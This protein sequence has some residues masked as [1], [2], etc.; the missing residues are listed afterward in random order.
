MKTKKNLNRHQLIHSTEEP[1]K[2]YKC[3]RAFV[4]FDTFKRHMIAKHKEEYYDVL[5]EAE[6][7][8]INSEP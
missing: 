7:K 4:R 2:C 5:K 3:N 6:T 8:K 1:V